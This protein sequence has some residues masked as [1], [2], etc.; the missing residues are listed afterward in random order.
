MPPT[1]FL[2]A[3]RIWEGLAHLL[4]ICIKVSELLGS[5]PPCLP[6]QLKVTDE[7]LPC[8]TDCSRL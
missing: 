3:S 1:K 2:E 4:G 5:R 6:V 8:H 7:R